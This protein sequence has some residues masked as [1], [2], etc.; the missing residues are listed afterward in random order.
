MNEYVATNDGQQH[1]PQLTIVEDA[2]SSTPELSALREARRRAVDARVAAER[3][4][5]DAEEAEA[6]LV[7][8]EELAVASA[9][10]ARREKAS[11]AA[12]VAASREREAL[13]CVAQ[14]EARLKHSMQ[15]KEHAQIAASSVAQSRIEAQ[16]A[17]DRLDASLAGFDEQLRAAE[18][19][20]RELEAELAR[21]R[22]Q[23]LAATQAREHAVSIVSGSPALISAPS[24]V[25]VPA[26]VAAP[27]ANPIADQPPGRSAVVSDLLAIAAQRAAER[28][29]A[30]AARAQVR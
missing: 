27:V 20:E 19:T 7:A 21:V 12:R 18:A 4:L 13:E 16:R 24:A 26:L 5:R 17:L 10:A 6:G 1:P 15:A 8:Q 14:I 2:E 23:A 25:N 9:L 11:E 29:A 30:D 3:A 22:D 28:R